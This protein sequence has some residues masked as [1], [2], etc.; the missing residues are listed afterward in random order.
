MRVLKAIDLATGYNFQSMEESNLQLLMSSAVAAEFE[1][2][3]IGKIQEKF[4][5]ADETVDLPDGD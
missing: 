4:I 2:E 1:Y 5:G 3:K